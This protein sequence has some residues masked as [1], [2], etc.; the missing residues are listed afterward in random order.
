MF[1]QFA[2][3]GAW[4]PVLYPFLVGHRGLGDG[5]AGAVVA[6]LG[7]GAFV[8]PFVAGQVADRHARADR[9]LALGH[10]GGAA[11]LLALASAQR[12]EVL[13]PLALLFGLVFAP[14]VSL[15]HAVTL[16]HVPDRRRDFARVRLWG[17]LG[18]IASGLAVG[19]WLLAR[20]TPAGD[21]VVVRAAQDAG[22]RDGLLLAA[23]LAAAA[24]LFAWL[25][26]PAT[27]PNRAGER[28]YAPLAALGAVCRSRALAVLFAVAV[29]LACLDRFT[30]VHGAEFLS[31]YG[32]GAPGAV[33]RWLGVGGVGV[34]TLGQMTELV[35]LLALP[36]L[37]ARV[38]HR[39]VLLVGAA[40]FALRLGTFALV[41]AE[42]PVLAAVATHGVS[43]GCFFFLGFLVVDEETTDDVRASAQG[44]FQL[45]FGGVG[46][47][48]GSLAAAWAGGWARGVDGTLDPARL[49]GPPAAV[50]ALCALALALAYPRRTAARGPD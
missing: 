20:H 50:A 18:W 34:L 21:E 15:A 22:R 41:P 11:L 42:G 45:V 30:L 32:Q 6:A 38:S 25:A 43:F 37:T 27:H 16:A 48:F 35:V 9:L 1:L 8:A 31:R 46:A 3:P 28:R 36:W 33:D 19:H 5:Q 2:V 24:A 7:V 12:F 44:L 26:L 14:T 49:F 10:L 13:L 4:L 17:T 29:P 23:A 40:A 39:R 47:V